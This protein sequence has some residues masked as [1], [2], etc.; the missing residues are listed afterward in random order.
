MLN[1][2]IALCIGVLPIC[3]VCQGSG[4]RYFTKRGISYLVQLLVPEPK[5]PVNS[6]GKQGAHLNH[7]GRSVL[8][9]GVLF[10]LIT[11]V[12]LI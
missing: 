9:R 12:I 10:S 3:H 6:I 4:S 2:L 8:E 11:V 5:L 7:C 1:Q